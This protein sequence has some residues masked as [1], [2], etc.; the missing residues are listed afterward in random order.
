M[1]HTSSTGAAMQRELSNQWFGG[2][3][4][5]MGCYPRTLL[6]ASVFAFAGCHRGDDPAENL[7]G[8]ELKPPSPDASPVTAKEKMPGI[9]PAGSRIKDRDALGGFGP[10]DN[11]PKE[12]AGKE[13][14]AKGAVSIVAF[15]DEPVA[16]FKHR[17]FALRVVNRT[18]EAVPF[19]ACDSA[20][21]IVREAQD[22]GGTW[23]EIESPPQAI[24]GNSFHR[25]FLGPGQYWEFPAREYAGPTKTKVR[26]R[27]GPGG[28]R[29]AIYSK[30]FDGQV[31]AAQ[32]G[33][34]G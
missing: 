26:F 16:Y 3:G 19:A 31:T 6:I 5:G 15:P 10:C 32:L 29:P 9:Y 7:Q 14:G 8:W 34:G 28:D 27:L 4:L 17:G 18:T 11:H 20:L 22:A 12:L 23:R 25:V 13:W 2:G 21:S 30:E 1:F 33:A 24:C